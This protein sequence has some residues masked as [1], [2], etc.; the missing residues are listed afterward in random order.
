MISELKRERG[1]VLIT[2]RDNTADEAR[3]FVNSLLDTEPNA[4]GDE[5]RRSMAQ[6]TRG[7]PL[8]AVELLRGMQERGDLARA[9]NG[10]WQEART[11]DWDRLPARVEGII[12]QRINRLRD[13]LREMLTTASVQGE[14]FTV[15]IVAKLMQVDER[16]L[17]AACPR[18]S[19]G[20]TASFARRTRSASA[21]C[22]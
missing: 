4:L 19:T 10:Q 6:R 2:L 17:L 22:D 15:Q 11:L 5:F 8:F 7:H 13:E 1:E 16:F 20:N 9:A 14:L 3:Q 18:S 21:T 12:E